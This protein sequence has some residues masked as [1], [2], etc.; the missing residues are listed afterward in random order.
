MTAGPAA[1]GLPLLIIG[2]GTRDATGVA[3]FRQLIGRVRDQSA[4]WLPAVDGGFI[5]LSAPSVSEVVPRLAGERL[6]N[7]GPAELVAVPLVLSAAGH[8]K[9]DIPAALAREQV[10]H[11]GLRYRYG[12][13]LGPHPV[14][15]DVLE[16]R[17][18]AA[19]ARDARGGQAGGT[20]APAR[21]ADARAG[22]H[23]VL[24][25]RGSTDPDGNAEVAKVARLLWE[26][27]GYADVTLSFISL[28]EPSVPAAL[29]R[30]RRLGAERIVVAP[31]FL[32][33]GVL[34]DRVTAQ[35]RR[36]RG[37]A[38]GDRRA[39]G[40]ADRRLRRTGRAGPRAVCGG[41]ARRHQDELR[42]VRVPDC[43]ARVR[44][45]GRAGADPAP[46]P[47]RHG[48]RARAP[49]GLALLAGTGA[50]RRA[51]LR[52]GKDP[53]PRW[54][55]YRGDGDLRVAPGQPGPGPV[56]APTIAGCCRRCRS[57]GRAGCPASW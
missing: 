48:R 54:G 11:P 57:T 35:A 55:G 44:G 31:Y 3:Q 45:Q 49:L 23:V 51:L 56:T 33:A 38:P 17:I 18:D 26:G 1:G 41:T 12:R 2:H 42:H 21:A 10:R 8:G 9:G 13:P 28:T 6:A 43:D 16:A 22:T 39:G 15:L 29:E 5:E 46:S 40:R 27:R 52:P 34:P 36:V 14:L 30:A 50:L 47:A 25:G 4:G 7:G 19:L 32:F 24:V 37:A 53:S 20:E